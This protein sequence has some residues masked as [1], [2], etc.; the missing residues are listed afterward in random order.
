MDKSIEELKKQFYWLDK[1]TIRYYKKLS[2]KTREKTNLF[3]RDIV[4][5]EEDKKTYY[6]LIDIYI[7]KILNCQNKIAHLNRELFYFSEGGEM[8]DPK[9]EKICKDT[10][11][12]VNFDLKYRKKIFHYKNI[13]KNFDNFFVERSC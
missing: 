1:T 13:I 10:H 4:V 5:S 12:I 8:K 2:E 3:F 9:Y 11:L 7:I 6:D